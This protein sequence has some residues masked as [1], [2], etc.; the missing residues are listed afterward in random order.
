MAEPKLNLLFPETHDAKALL[1]ADISQYPVPFSIVNP[2]VEITV[3]GFNVLTL[4]FNA[5]NFTVYNSMSL[6]I[7]CSDVDCDL[8]DLPD[9]IYY[10][11]Y[12]ITPAYRYFVNKSFLRIN[13]LQEKF[14]KVYLK[15]DFMQ[16][17]Q[18]IKEE[19]LEVL[20]TI[21][22]YMNGAVAAAN[23]CLDTLAMKLYQKA[24]QYIDDFVNHRCYLK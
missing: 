19:D 18:A 24:S 9:G 6:N 12:S 1:I 13:K 5:Q 23:N 14:D 7:T 15:L 8:I 22:I 16:C 17:D 21:E 10:V 4:A 2:T 11:K 20:N 3:P